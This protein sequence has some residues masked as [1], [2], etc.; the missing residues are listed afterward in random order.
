MFA[1]VALP[2]KVKRRLTYSIPAE[3]SR[4]VKLGTVVQVPLKGRQGRGVVVRLEGESGGIGPVKDIACVPDPELRI[5]RESLRLAA[6]MSKY[7]LTSLG[8]VLKLFLP[9]GVL[10]VERLEAKWIRREEYPE[11]TDDALRRIYEYVRDRGGRWIGTPGMKKAFSFDVH[12]R[13]LRLEELGLVALRRTLRV[14]RER[15]TSVSLEEMSEGF[16]PTNGDSETAREIRE[17]YQREDKPVLVMGLGEPERSGTVLALIRDVLD[18]GGGVL[19]LIPERTSLSR[20]GQGLLGE[21][22]GLS[23]L[24]HGGLTNPVRLKL[25]KDMRRGR[26]RLVIGPRSALFLPVKDLRLILLDDEHDES[27]KQRENPPLYGARDVAVMRGRYSGASVVLM[28]E[29]PSMESLHNSEEGKFDLIRAEPPGKSPD[30]VLIDMCEEPAS[31]ILS[32]RLLEEVRDTVK[33]GRRTVFFLNRRGFSAGIRCLDC[34]HIPECPSCSARFTFHEDR[35]RLICHLCGTKGDVLTLCPD[36]G[37]TK[38]VPFG[39]GTQRAEAELRRL[40]PEESVLRLDTDAKVPEEIEEDIK[41]IVGT[42]ALFGALPERWAD[43]GCVLLADLGLGVPDFRAEERTFQTL[44]A[45]S[46]LVRSEGRLLVQ[47]F[48]PESLAL[49]HLVGGDTRRF[50]EEEMLSRKG[51]KY[52]PYRRLALIEV[53]GRDEGRLMAFAGRLKDSL[54]RVSGGELEVLGPA[55]SPLERVRGISRWRIL[56]LS[57]KA[58][59]F[60]RAMGRIDPVPTRGVRMR[61]DVDPVTLM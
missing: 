56:V 50:S 24:Y 11:L 21:F 54:D 16:E 29:T 32:I 48:S 7:Y 2:G 30:V 5:P 12:S 44:H 27:Y 15:E 4:D 10:G 43:L 22:Q 8:E 42:Q 58:F 57:E 31:S 40:F 19:C 28:S 45:I 26:I 52:P 35:G 3:M 34:G 14:P 25:W 36:C 6:W 1:L 18:S 47:T 49:K 51:S 59:A 46:D 39:Y 38:F 53:R 13:L 37:S 23:A 17:R 20:L 55:P 60:Q 41:M 61:V 9:R 33:T